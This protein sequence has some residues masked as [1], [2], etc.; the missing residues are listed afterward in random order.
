MFKNP[1]H[2]LIACFLPVYTYVV[3]TFLSFFHQTRKRP[4]T[5][6][7]ETI[8]KDVNPSM[9]AILI[10]WLVEVSISAARIKFTISLLATLLH[11]I[12]AFFRAGC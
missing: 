12:D 3:K 10:D 9:R 11:C 2:S 6:F 4:S 5:D 8:Q 7:L 1:R